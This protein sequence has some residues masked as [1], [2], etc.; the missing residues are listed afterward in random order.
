MVAAVNPTRRQVPFFPAASSSQLR[1]ATFLLCALFVPLIPA[2]AAA[3]SSST[4]ADAYIVTLHPGAD[5]G[6]VA[7]EFKLKPRHIYRHALNGFAVSL[8]AKVVKKL[9]NDKR[10]LAVERDGKVELCSQT[11][12]TGIQRMG[13]TNFP[14]ARINGLDDR[15]NVDVAVLDGGIQ[16]NHPDLNVVQA[17][18]F[19]D[20]G[21][22]GDDWHGH[23]TAMAGIIGA[24][25]N[26]FGVVGVAPGVRLWSVQVI[27]PI[28]AHW[29]NVLAGLDYIAT[30]ANEIE[31]VNVSIGGGAERIPYVACRQAFSNVV[32]LG[33]VIVAGAGNNAVDI[34][35]FDEI[36]GTEDDE[37]PAALPEVMTVSAMNP[38]NDTVWQ[39][40]NFAFVPKSPSYVNSLGQGLDVTAPGVNTLSTHLGGG[41]ASGSGTSDATAHVTGL[42]ALYIA[43]NGRAHSA[44]DVYRIR[45]AIVDSAQPQSQWRVT[46]SDEDGNPEP[47]AVASSIWLPQPILG[48]KAT[49]NGFE[50]GF[51]TVPRHVYTLQ[52]TSSLSAS[53]GWTSL[54]STNGTGALATLI[55]PAVEATRFYRLLRTPFVPLPATNT[56]EWNFAAGNLSAALGNGVLEYADATT[57]N[58]TTF[59]VTDGTNVPHIGIQPASYMAVP[60]M[61]GS[62]SGYRVSLPASGPNGGGL[63]LNQYT[64]IQ[65][66]LLPSPRDWTALFNTDPNNGNT[67]EFYVDANGQLTL[68]HQY[69]AWEH[70]GFIPTDTWARFAFVADLRAYCCGGP[71][72]IRFFVDGTQIYDSDHTEAF[73]DGP[74]SISLKGLK[75]GDLRLFND[76]TN[77]GY[78]HPLL[79][80]A[81]AFVD[82]AMTTNEIAALG[83]PKAS[84]IFT[85][86][87]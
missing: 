81:W 4:T 71:G 76:G 15:I 31:V 28:Q 29:A 80:S 70:R 22:N 79:V 19:A 20:P 27:T 44:Q 9:K 56:Y 68:P 67:A 46:D 33:V 52:F 57:S 25:D 26:D 49:V 45:Q 74:F 75:P 6:K 35:G 43:A 51:T 30:N 72:S 32:N 36:P 69:P 53:N 63:Y 3:P 12:P 48:P 84:G 23:G 83:G 82:R 21:L 47:L 17:V 61:P 58:L 86:G 66:V 73:R 24:L 8:D 60:Q 85:E 87:P 14:V 59:A 2:L 62:E 77:P 1:F 42:V 38:T 55:D 64:I 10:V 50:L 16:T 40:S 39:G 7:K 11:I 34:F 78:T 13:L 41:Y 65:D 18:G 54:G 37:L 5:S